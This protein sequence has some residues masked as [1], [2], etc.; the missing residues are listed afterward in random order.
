M[1]E[2]WL[3]RH[4]ATE[5]SVDGRHTSTTDLPLL[6]EGEEVARSLRPRL[7]DGGFVQVLTSPRRRARE[8]AELAGFGSAEID[9]R[10]VEWDYG[11]YEGRTTADIRETVPGWTVWTHPAPGGESAAAVAARLDEVVA[12]ARAVDGPTLVFAHSHALRALAARWLG[13]PV[14]HGAHLRLDTAT[15]SV[16][17]W[18]RE[19]P[20]ILHWNS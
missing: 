13:L 3:V 4:G 11:D 14:A 10:L 5:W 6:P 9:D 2:L 15:V 1:N 7:A 18:E 8:T 16:L 12:R 20:V 17:G 19:T